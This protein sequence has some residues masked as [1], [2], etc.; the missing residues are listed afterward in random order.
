MN[1]SPEQLPESC[2][3]LVIGAGPAGSAA[4]RVLAQA[5]LD[6]VMVD[7]H[8]FPR[9]KICGD[10]L[11]PDAHR[12]LQRLGVF[13]AVMARAQPC[14]HVACVGSRGSVIEV[15]GSLAVLPRRELD[16]L[17]LA[18]AV[19]AGA[20][21]FAPLRFVGLTEQN[22]RVTGARLSM[23]SSGDPERVLTARWVLLATGAVPQGLMAAGMATRQ[24][25]SA[26]AMR[27][28]IRH[29]GLHER[30]EQLQIVWHQAL[31]GGYGWIF[32]CGDSVFNIGVCLVGERHG[33]SANLRQRMATFGRVHPAARRLLEEGVAL[34]PM[35][36]APLRTT[37]RGARFSR[38]GLL[39][40]GEAAGTTYSL[41]GEGIGKAMET[42]IGA[43]E[44]LLNARA[45]GRPDHEVL[46]QY[47]ALLEALRP[48][49]L[50]YERANLINRFPWVTEPVIWRA[51]RSPWLLG[52]MSGMLE[53]TSN[54]G[55]LLTLRGFWRMLRS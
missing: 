37:L 3:V 5:G 29:E 41:T 1:R 24:S 55:N 51:R 13:E 8:L 18:A 44:R 28:Y 45:Q 20:R 16:L 35:K 27:G 49:F 32:P 36:G 19:A 33:A 9:D 54:P 42:G 53:E 46:A 10:G 26:V 23:P 52:K 30:A 43:A 17:L 31:A 11:I 22:G 40:I 38:P 15:P 6:V 4:A 47:E 2:D 14:T 48:Q 21:M 34:G 7:Q 39:V 50:L 25:P 12:A